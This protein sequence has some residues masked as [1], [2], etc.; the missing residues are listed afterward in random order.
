MLL[1]VIA[2]LIFAG[3]ST[4]KPIKTDLTVETAPAFGL[5]YSSEKDVLYSRTQTDPVT[6]IVEQVDF[7]ALASA[8]ALAQAE[9]EKVQAEAAKAQAEALSAAVQALSRDAASVLS[10]PVVP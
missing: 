8:A 5:Q 3:C 2:L 10:P 7:K 4:P 6:G 1:A 9:R